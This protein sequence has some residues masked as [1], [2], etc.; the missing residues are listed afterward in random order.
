MALLAL[1]ADTGVSPRPSSSDY[2]VHASAK[3]ATLAAA[4]V[5]PEQVKRILSDY[6]SS[7]YVVVEV[8][9]YPRDG[10]AF[11]V[12]SNDFAL[13]TGATVIHAET[14]WDVAPW[15]ENR[16]SVPSRLPVG[17]TTETGVVYTRSSDPVNGRR[18]GVG[19]YE[20]VTVT[21]DPRVT[22]PRSSS[23]SGPDPSV[24]AQ[25]A[26]DKALP[27][28]QARTPVAGYVYFRQYSKRTQRGCGRIAILQRRCAGE[29]AVSQVISPGQNPPPKTPALEASGLFPEYAQPTGTP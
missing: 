4:I 1:G 28:V 29:V 3:T 17:V 27:Q 22:N 14:P 26:L 16:G 25:K 13:K 2:P 21:N 7:R 23:P 15:P 10:N 24:T 6:V 20:G 19:T 18:Q 9:V 5:P 12:N 11:D 8:A